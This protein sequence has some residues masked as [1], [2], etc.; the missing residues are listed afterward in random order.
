MKTRNVR[1]LTPQSVHAPSPPGVLVYA[2]KT[3]PRALRPA[4]MPWQ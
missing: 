2:R 4:A 3:D 1:A